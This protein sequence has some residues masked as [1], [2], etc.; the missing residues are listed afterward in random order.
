MPVLCVHEHTWNIV[1]LYS[2][3][4]SGVFVDAVSFFAWWNQKPIILGRLIIWQ[5]GSIHRRFL[6]V[7]NPKV[8]KG[9][10]HAGW[11]YQHMGSQAYWRCQYTSARKLASQFLRFQS[12]EIIGVFYINSEIRWPS[13]I[14]G[15]MKLDSSPEFQ[16]VLAVCVPSFEK[17][18]SVLLVDLKD[19]GGHF[20][21]SRWPREICRFCI[22]DLSTWEVFS[23]ISNIHRLLGQ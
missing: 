11:R 20:G 1:N 23:K 4:V 8:S 19:F 15:D 16:D 14:M 22:L 12:G 6:K 17:E 2:A 18:P 5:E 3:S 13:P 10:L 7:P 21:G 9:T